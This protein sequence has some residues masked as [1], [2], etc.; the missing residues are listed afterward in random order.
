[1]VNREVSIDC[2]ARAIRPSD[3]GSSLNKKHED[4]EVNDG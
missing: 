4:L 2:T 3:E 1:M